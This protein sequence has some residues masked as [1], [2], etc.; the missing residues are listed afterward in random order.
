M[1]NI[2]SSQ[3][4]YFLI[5]FHNKIFQNVIELMILYLDFVLLLVQETR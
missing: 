4:V 1:P 5:D 3:F 2:F